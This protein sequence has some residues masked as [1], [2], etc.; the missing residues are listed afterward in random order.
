MRQMICWHQT[1]TKKRDSEVYIVDSSLKLVIM[2]C[3][4]TS[5]V[6]FFGVDT[7][8]HVPRLLLDSINIFIVSK[9]ALDDTILRKKW[10][11]DEDQLLLILSLHSRVLCCLICMYSVK[12][13]DWSVKVLQKLE[14]HF[15]ATKWRSWGQVRRSRQR[16]CNQFEIQPIWK[17]DTKT[18]I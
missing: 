6:L 10:T 13:S 8:K 15:S 2:C 9:L 14:T 12:L 18:V 7:P 17:N 4:Q 1:T 3:V 16:W 11:H 5:D